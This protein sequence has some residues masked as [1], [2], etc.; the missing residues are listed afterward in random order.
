MFDLIVFRGLRF[1]QHVLC[2]PFN[3]SNLAV[4]IKLGSKFCT[5]PVHPPSTCSYVKQLCAHKMY[6]T[7]SGENNRESD[8]SALVE[9]LTSD[10]ETIKSLTQAMMPALLEGL[11]QVGRESPP[12]VVSG[13]QVRPL[14]PLGNQANNVAIPQN[15][16]NETGTLS[17]NE[18]SGNGNGNEAT[19]VYAWNAPWNY[20]G[21][22]YQYPESYTQG[23]PSWFNP[24]TNLPFYPPP[25]P[26]VRGGA[27]CEP[28]SRKR[29]RDQSSLSST[30]SSDV[31]DSV[32]PSLSTEEQ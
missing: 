7:G 26:W 17:G 10:P 29:T 2:F 27:D 24:A 20:Q 16:S 18:A 25:P 30:V 5:C 23:H 6:S 13:N 8:S 21:Q 4:S 32:E 9:R 22:G 3:I 19:V 1:N 31:E 28:A 12:W 11:S 15:S 14:G